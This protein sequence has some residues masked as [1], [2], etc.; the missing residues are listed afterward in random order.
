[1]LPTRWVNQHKLRYSLQP[2]WGYL[3]NK[4][5]Y[6]ICH[7]TWQGTGRPTFIVVLFDVMIYAFKLDAICIYRYKHTNP[8]T[9]EKIVLTICTIWLFNIATENHHF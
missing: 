8:Q 5:I 1:M 7:A 6:V 3:T 9:T 2:A 4:Q